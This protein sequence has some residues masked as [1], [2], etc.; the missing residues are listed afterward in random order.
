MKIPPTPIYEPVPEHTQRDEDGREWQVVAEA[1]EPTLCER[2]L[3]GHDGGTWAALL[4]DKEY[5]AAPMLVHTFPSRADAEERSPAIVR[6]TIMDLRAE[7][8]LW[9]YSSGMPG[10]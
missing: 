2:Y 9:G 6:G 3:L 5:S 8:G 4:G 10:M 7:A 1:E